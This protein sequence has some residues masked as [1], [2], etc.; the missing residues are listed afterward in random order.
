MAS[1][2]QRIF[3]GG[4]SPE[5]REAVLA[6]MAE[7]GKL[8]A[9][10]DAA[11]GR[12][13]NVLT[14]YGGSATPGTEAM[15]EIVSAAKQQSEHKELCAGYLRRVDGRAPFKAPPVCA[16]GSIMVVHYTKTGRPWD[17]RCGHKT[18]KRVRW[19]R[20]DCETG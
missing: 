8:Q 6:Y 10:Q 13:N 19:T 12:Y 4:T 14:K 1:F 17:W 11:G 20:G 5:R 18:C 9:I 7:E 3:G 2:I 16:K 15:A